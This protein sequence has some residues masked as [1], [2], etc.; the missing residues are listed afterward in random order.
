M[1]E[2]KTGR[3]SARPLLTWLQS[4]LTCTPFHARHLLGILILLQCTNEALRMLIIH[5]IVNTYTF[6]IYNG[7]NDILISVNNMETLMYK[8]RFSPNAGR[9]TASPP[10]SHCHST[11]ASSPYSISSTPPPTNS[12]TNNLRNFICNFRLKSEL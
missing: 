3:S 2:D 5:S 1:L 4:T 9:H 10:P 8:R 6:I 7:H 11:N 12:W